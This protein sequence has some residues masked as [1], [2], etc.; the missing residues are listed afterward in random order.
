MAL[1]LERPANIPLVAFVAL[2]RNESAEATAA[3]GLNIDDPAAEADAPPA[4]YGAAPVLPP[5]LPPSYRM[6]GEY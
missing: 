4:A 6:S 5:P 1:E 2:L 3:D